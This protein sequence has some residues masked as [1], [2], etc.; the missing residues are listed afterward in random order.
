VLLPEYYASNIFQFTAGTCIAWLAYTVIVG[1]IQLRS[2]GIWIQLL[3]LLSVI[4]A[5]LIIIVLFKFKTPK[6]MFV[7]QVFIYIAYL[8]VVIVID[9][10]Y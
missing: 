4:F 6:K 5:K 1:E 8:C 3:L 9:Y 7:I 2:E 10:T